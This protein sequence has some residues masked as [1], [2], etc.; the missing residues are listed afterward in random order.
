MNQSQTKQETALIRLMP[1]ARRLAAILARSPEKADDLAQEAFIKVWSRLKGGADIQDLRPYLMTTL[2]NTHRRTAQ[3]PQA[4]T[5][6]N[7]PACPGDAFGRVACHQVST[8]IAAL[9]ASHRCLLDQMVHQGA[10]Y[11]E[12][13]NQA[14]LPIGTVM[15]RIA[16]AR[17]KLRVQLELPADNAVEALLDETD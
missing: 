16:R 9:P 17:Q 2:R 14:G 13:A 6:T 15:S 11:Q 3:E 7:T 8:A 12:L 1:P 10:T 4:L 5:E